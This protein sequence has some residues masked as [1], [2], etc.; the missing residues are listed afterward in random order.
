MLKL[1][2]FWLALML[3]ALPLHA[4]EINDF[5]P[6]DANNTARWPEGMPFAAV[7]NAARAD[8]GLLGRYHRDTNGSLT[9][10]GSANAYV[11]S[12]NQTL[13][14]YYAGMRLTA[15][16]NFTNTGAATINVD[17]LGA[18]SISNVGVNGL[19]SG[20]VYDFVYDGTNFQVLGQAAEL[21][22]GT[23]IVFFQATCPTGWTQDA[24]QNN[25]ALRIVSGTGAG[26]GGTTAFSTVFASRTPAGTVGDTAISISQMPLHGHPM[27]LSIEN[28]SSS[29]LAGGIMLNDTNTS[30]F[31]AFTGAVSDSQGQQIGGTGGGNTH[32]HSFTGT[33]MDFDVLRIDVIICTRD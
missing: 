26:T 29:N 25:K 2:R 33:P 1:M 23:K 12:A 15:K 3:L 13:T 7:N 14:A 20:R 19:I 31:A 17:G 9:T 21:P 32:T 18:K 11:L 4:A 6:V 27:R 10:T 5:D 28:T 30:S 24:T 22:T 16:V 8:E